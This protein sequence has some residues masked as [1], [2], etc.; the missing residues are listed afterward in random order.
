L[1][2]VI[3][4]LP[5]A[6]S[7]MLQG[8]ATNTIVQT[9]VEDRMRGRV[10]A[11]FTMAFLGMMPFGSLAAGAIAH[12]VGVPMT[13][14]IGGIVAAIAGVLAMRVKLALEPRAVAGAGE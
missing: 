11:Y 4:V 8:G 12:Q 10:M 2:V 3:L 5:T 7:L 9:L 14:A 6:F 13:L 1:A